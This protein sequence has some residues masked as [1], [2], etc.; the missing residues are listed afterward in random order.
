MRGAIVRKVR[1]SCTHSILVTFETFVVEARSPVLAGA[2]RENR[3]VYHYPNGSEIAVLGMDNY[4][5]I[6]SSE[7][8]FIAV[9][10]ATELTELEFDTLCTRG[11]ARC[12][13]SRSWRIAIR[14]A[15]TTG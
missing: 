7:F 1:A 2:G 8:D 5:R 14:A 3:S 10:E 9:F 6:M 13:T 12:R 15:P 4:D 11:T